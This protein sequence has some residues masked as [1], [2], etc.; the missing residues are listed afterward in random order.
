M[1]KHPG[2][3]NP[4]FLYK[5]L[6]KKPSCPLCGRLV[7]VVV[8]A[9]TFTYLVHTQDDVCVMDNQPKEQE[10]TLRGKNG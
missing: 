7:N 5:P 6:H 3:P 10:I 9:A 4:S 8:P 1:P 2:Y